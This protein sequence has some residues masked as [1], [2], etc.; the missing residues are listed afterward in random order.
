MGQ[1]SA[2]QERAGEPV[3]DRFQGDSAA[4]FDS[5]ARINIPGYEAMHD[6]AS[7]ILGR[8]VPANARLL[9]VGAGTGMELANLG[10]TNTGWRFTGVDPS[11]DMLAV[12]RE[13]LTAR[14]IME[15]V[16][17]HE[18][19]VH[20]LPAEDKFDAAT[21]LLVMHFLPDDGAKAR[22]LGAI[23]E[24]LRP[25][26]V[27]VLVDQHG[28]RPSRAF[29]EQLELWKR[30]HMLRGLSAED[31]EANMTRRLSHNHFVPE[32]RIVE[33]LREAGFEQVERFYQAFVVG[34]WSA[35]RA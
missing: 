27:L 30:F 10:G 23:A 13:V 31:A 22:F 8:N 35:R 32:E 21:S 6:M 1:D 17:L 20:E 9:V 4:Q 19:L 28:S 26:A 11:G 15:R 3:D 5:R 2:G 7:A 29:D 24:R 16:H 18:G 34:G 12:A 14:G 33:L 25:G